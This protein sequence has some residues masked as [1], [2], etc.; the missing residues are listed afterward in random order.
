MLRSQ[1]K[2][3]SGTSLEAPDKKF[4]AGGDRDQL[5]PSGRQQRDQ[6]HL[7]KRQ[8]A[9]D[10]D[11]PTRPEWKISCPSCGHRTV[12][13]EAFRKEALRLGKIARITMKQV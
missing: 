8:F 6:C 2:S 12:L 7:V 11:A 13:C 9:S 3:T 1:P 10:A 5:K 4:R